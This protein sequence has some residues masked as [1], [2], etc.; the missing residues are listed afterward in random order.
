MHTLSVPNE[1]SLD[2]IPQPQFWWLGSHRLHILHTRDR[3][4]PWQLRHFYYRHE[5]TTKV[6]MLLCLS[7]VLGH[8]CTPILQLCTDLLKRMHT[9]PGDLLQ[10]G[11]VL[12]TG[13]KLL[14]H[15]VD[16]ARGKL[17]Y[18][19]TEAAHEVMFLV[20]GYGRLCVE[21]DEKH[22]LTVGL[23]RP[24]DLFGEEALLDEPERESAFEAVL[25]SQVDVIAR[26]DFTA[27][28]SMHSEMQRAIMEHLAQRLL[29][30]QRHMIRL[31]FEPLERRLSWILLE[32]ASATTQVVAAQSS[33]AA[34]LQQQE[35]PE[36][37]IYHKDLAALLGV[38]RETITATLNRWS[39]EG[40]IAQRP[41]SIVLKDC[42]RLQ[43]MAEDTP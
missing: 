8:L 28:V 25:H 38:W 11:L 41:G 32:L 16:I 24:G 40:I 15:R 23:V 37:T 14:A 20:S 13:L 29:I 36:I 34:S 19:E 6:S 43:H 35:P 18:R 17:L 30:Q 9:L 3:L 10:A 4:V 39:N 21:H 33:D 5:S 27:Y 42:Q 1:N 31:A 22:R 7:L 12:P 26:K 2:S